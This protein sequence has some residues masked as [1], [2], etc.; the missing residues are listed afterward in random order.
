MMSVTPIVLLFFTVGATRI[1]RSEEEQADLSYENGT[2][3]AGGCVEYPYIGLTGKCCTSKCNGQ[4]PYMSFE[5]T[6]HDCQVKMGEVFDKKS[7]GVYKCQEICT[8]KAVALSQ[9]QLSN[10][11][12]FGKK[13][14]KEERTRYITKEGV[15]ISR[16]RRPAKAHASKAP[17]RPA[18]IPTADPQTATQAPSMRHPGE[19]PDGWSSRVQTWFG[20]YPGFSAMLPPEAEMWTDQE[21]DVYFG[22]NGDIWPRG[23][24][25][26]WFGKPSTEP[27]TKSSSK[28]QGPRTYPD[29]KVHF[30]T[31]DLAETTPPEIIRRHYRRLA[32][33][34]HPDKHPENV[35]E[36]TR[37]FQQVTEAYE[38][39]ANRLK[40]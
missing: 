19:I 17:R 13:K 40:L 32:R 3:M 30:Q 38:A 18:E 36:A 27:E 14:T 31:L 9:F 1:G 26:A 28:V 34:I 16:P 23:K 22:S 11:W 21:L 35:E 10:L 39:I 12:P 6:F 20:R 8:L 25:P 29:L 24:R 2:A 4:E 7:S 15:L 5:G 33:D 37:R